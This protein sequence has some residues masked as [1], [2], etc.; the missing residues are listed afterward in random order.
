MVALPGEFDLREYLTSEEGIALDDLPPF[1]VCGQTRLTKDIETRIRAMEDVG[2]H[3]WHWYYETLAGL[4]VAWVLWLLGL[5]LIGRRKRLR[6]Q[7]PPPPEPSPADLMA[8]YFAALAR[9]DLSVG[10]KARLEILL[11]R[12]WRE[13]LCP[14]PERMA[15][16]CRQMQRDA[17]VGQ[18]YQALEAWLHDPAGAVG[19]AE[20]LH[21]CDPSRPVRSR[22]AAP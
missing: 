20:I 7:A 22:Q 9:G 15:A 6:R 2:V 16:A 10:D 3:F 18:A 4:A 5:I 11:L 13:R 1:K 8:G 19:P 17:G 12:Y 21:H 14:Q